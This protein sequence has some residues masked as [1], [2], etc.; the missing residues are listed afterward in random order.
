MSEVKKKY[1]SKNGLLPGDLRQEQLIERMIRVDQAGEYGAVRIYEGQLSVLASSDSAPVIKHM[2]DQEIEHLETF[3]EILKKRRV[4]PTALLPLWHL[5]GFALGAGTALM[6]KKAAMACTV[7]VEEVIDE[8]YAAQVEKLEC[9][10]NDEKSLRDTCEKFRE[11]ELE[12]RKIGLEHG[13]EQT[14]GYEALSAIVK[15]GSR[16]AIWFSERI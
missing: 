10:G 12:H 8:H 4:R 2:L 5:A 7:A 6:G 16:M 11:E 9:M 1:S 13:A 3:S 15:T 14:P